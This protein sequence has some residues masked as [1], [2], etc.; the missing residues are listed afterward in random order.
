LPHHRGRSVW[1]P[2]T[3]AKTPFAAKEAEIATEN[4]AVTRIF[5]L[6][7][8]PYSLNLGSGKLNDLGI[9]I[10][11]VGRIQPN[12]VSPPITESEIYIFRNVAQFLNPF[13]LRLS[14]FPSGKLGA[15]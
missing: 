15:R 1:L 7:I 14:T 11:E 6:V 8:P 9:E 13:K 12:T 10:E 4:T 3:C 5:R 2:A